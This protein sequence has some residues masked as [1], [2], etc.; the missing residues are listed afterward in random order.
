MKEAFSNIINNSNGINVGAIALTAN[1]SNTPRRLIAPVDYID[2]EIDQ[3]DISD[4]VYPK[5]IKIINSGD[6]ASQPYSTQSN[7]IVTNNLKLQLGGIT[8]QRNNI[9]LI[10]FQNI[11]IPQGASITSARITFVPESD[12]TSNIS[13]KILPE[14][15]GNSGPLTET[16]KS[17]KDSPLFPTWEISKEWK[18]D[19]RIEIIDGA[20][21][22]EQI[23]YITS[24]GDWCGNNSISFQL[25]RND[26]STSIRG[27][28]SFD[29]KDEYAPTLEIEFSEGNNDGCINPIIEI[30]ISS[31]SNN[32]IQ[33]D[34][35]SNNLLNVSTLE[36]SS[37]A[38]IGT[39]FEKLPIK[40]NSVLIEAHL[41]TNTSS[42][43]ASVNAQ[44]GIE[45]TDSSA[46]FGTSS[47]SRFSGKS[48][49]YES[50]KCNFEY[51]NNKTTEV[52][53]DI[54]ST[55]NEILKRQNWVHL[56]SISVFIKPEDSKNLKIL[57]YDNAQSPKLR[58]KLRKADLSK[59]FTYRDYINKQ[60]QALTSGTQSPANYNYTPIVP[61]LYDAANYIRTRNTSPIE[62]ACQPTHFVLLSDGSPNNTGSTNHTTLSSIGGGSCNSSYGSNERCGRELA[63]FISNENQTPWIN[64]S[65]NTIFTHTIGFALGTTNSNPQNC[66]F[67]GTNSSAAKFLCE[68]ASNG[69]GGY[70]SASNANDLTTVFDEIIR[71]VISTDATFVSA[72]APVNSFNRL[73]N[74]DEL[75][76]SLFRPMESD[77]WPGN[78]K[79][80]KL[81]INTRSIL[82]SR[83]NFAVDPQ[84]GYFSSTS[85]SFWSTVDDGNLTTQG[86]AAH[87]LPEANNRKIFTFLSG[88]PNNSALVS[89]TNVTDNNL[90]RD[91]N[92]PQVS[93][94]ERAELIEFIRGTE[95]GSP[96]KAIGD[97][98]HSSP[99]IV[100]YKSGDDSVIFGTNEGFVHV[101]NSSDGV[102]QMA[103]MPKTLLKNIKRLKSNAKTYAEQR[104]YGMDN[105]VALWVNDANGD[106]AILNPNDSVQ[107]NEF[108]Y[109]Y[110]TMG[111]GGR[112]IYALDITNRSQPKLM[113]Q[114][115]GGQT[116]GFE[117]LGQ[118]WSEPVKAKIKID[119]TITDVLIFAGGYDPDQDKQEE[120]DV[121]YVR[122]QDS[123][124]NDIYIVSAKTG[125]LIWSASANNID[126]KYSIPSK[127]SV[128]DLQKSNGGSLTYDPDGLADQFFVGD[129]GGQIWRFYINNE[130]SKANIVSPAN[131]TGVF[132]TLGGDGENARRFYHQPDIAL[133]RSNGQTKLAVSIG[134]GYRGHPLHKVIK[135]RYYSI[136]TTTLVKSDEPAN[137]APFEENDLA[138]LTNIT[139]LDVKDADGNVTTTGT[140]TAMN[141]KHGWLLKLGSNGE[142]VLSS[143]L[144]VNG[145]L[146]F[147]TYEPTAQSG[148]CVASV[149]LNRAYKVAL[150]DARPINNHI[151]IDGTSNQ[152]FQEVVTSGLLPDPTVVSIDNKNVLLRFPSIE[153]LP[154]VHLGQTYW[155]DMTEFD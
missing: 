84:T 52:S 145:H 80:Y 130:N 64:N 4:I 1:T 110:A 10:R 79:R 155:M 46:P 86:G 85:R 74:K 9:S 142:K 112:D 90:F 40:K 98:L 22:T 81:D 49:K 62:S 125:E 131:G 34:S 123:M 102:E 60:V 6:D 3:S 124:G 68:L 100:T 129:M 94:T 87:K 91:I 29:G 108:V 18:K 14:D 33:K 41:I 116:S 43:T 61:A 149:G 117:K 141:N 115:L 13:I 144:T 36:F 37:S 134:S 93:N 44:I 76:F 154:S 132:A 101:I 32:G 119:R 63:R 140:Q 65:N 153:E 104:P 96:R 24:R 42:G 47:D 67:S 106:G 53:C 122:N 38:L 66:T 82:D 97:P 56:N 88:N 105:T 16:N 135:D 25:S 113:W 69:Q 146:F 127:V 126:M 92:E 15:T 128:I 50:Q 133:L 120:G 152:R 137:S 11:P 57:A 83:N 139:K 20:D 12:S 103:F 28:Y 48:I 21:V 71:N 8:G 27:V 58:I 121:N 35:R 54:K 114:I 31:G 78:L 143:S 109:A 45:Q 138:D 136:H 75:Y 118:T 99:R 30:P 39:R 23:K 55:L 77:R 148:S 2:K 72:S 19:E 147:N 111:R 73:D 17:W 151:T 7:T 89:I 150:L 51:K 70:Y 59:K 95:G 107:T 5:S 26:N